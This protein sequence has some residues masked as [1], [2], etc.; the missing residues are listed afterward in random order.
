M[1]YEKLTPIEAHWTPTVKKAMLQNE[2]KAFKQVKV[3]EQIEIARGSGP[4]P[5]PQYV[6]LLLNVSTAFDK[7]QSTNIPSSSRRLLNIH[8]QS[9]QQLYYEYE[10]E[11]S[12]YE[13]P[14]EE[15]YFGSYAI[16]A[17]GF[18]PRRFRATLPKDIWTSLSLDDQKVW[19]QMSNKGK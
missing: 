17:S 12:Q 1:Q 14:S 5:F 19:D 13:P 2:F 3:Q 8:E 15:E 10:D 18:N 6:S 11:D 4:L 7:K 16:Q 9:D